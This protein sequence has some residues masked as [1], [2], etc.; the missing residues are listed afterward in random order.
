[1]VELTSLVDYVDCRTAVT[2]VQYRSYQEAVVSEEPETL[3]DIIP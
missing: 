1:M 2:V 3:P